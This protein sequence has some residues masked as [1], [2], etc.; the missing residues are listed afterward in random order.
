MEILPG[1]WRFRT[2]LQT[3]HPQLSRG[4]KA[5][6]YNALPLSDVLIRRWMFGFMIQII[7]HPTPLPLPICRKWWLCSSCCTGMGHWR[8]WGKS[9]ALDR[10]S[11]CIRHFFISRVILCP[12]AWL[13]LLTA[14][15]G[16]E[17][18]YYLCCCTR[19]IGYFLVWLSER[20]KL[21][22]SARSWRVH[23]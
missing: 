7:T 22:L 19:M 2:S 23:A 3:N 20:D 21:L 12:N 13:T 17:L 1:T 4:W 5:Y 6:P 16:R 8:L 14:N 9:G 11:S 10:Y 15:Y 18:Y